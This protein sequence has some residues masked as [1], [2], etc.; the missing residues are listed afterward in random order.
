MYN[1]LKRD[2]VLIALASIFMAFSPHISMAG[3][4]RK[5]I[6]FINHVEKTATIRSG[7]T[8]SSAFVGSVV[9][10]QDELI[11]DKDARLQVTLK[12]NSVITLGE[13]AR[14]VVDGF[15]FKEKKQKGR[16]LVTSLKG[17]FRFVTG[18]MGQFKN[19]KLSLATPVATIGIRGTDFWGGPIEGNYGVLL[20]EGQVIVKNRGGS[21]TLTEGGLGTDIISNNIAPGEPKAWSGEKISQ[22]LAQVELQ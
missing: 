9:R 7:K 2:V 19:K 14:L 13:S 10:L 5:P 20:L 18:R 16:L 6:G 22:A 17:A 11:T 4:D 15:V 8:V 3:S 1:L 21:V 12:D